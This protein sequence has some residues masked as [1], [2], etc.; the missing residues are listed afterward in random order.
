MFKRMKRIFGKRNN[1]GF[2][3]VEVIISCALLGILIAG[4]F[5]FVAPVM[6]SISIKEDNGRAL[7]LSEAIQTYINRSL[8]NSIY[9]LVIENAHIDDMVVGGNVPS[10]ASVVEMLATMNNPDYK[11]VYD[12]KCIGIRSMYDEKMQEYKYMLT[13]EFFVAGTASLDPTATQMVFEDCFYE[14][15][16]PKLTFK[17]LTTEVETGTDESGGPTLV[18]QEVPVIKTTADVYLDP[19]LTEL[20]F[21]QVG[22]INFGNIKS[23]FYNVSGSYKVYPYYTVRTPDEAKTAFPGENGLH[24]ATFIYY[25]TRKPKTAAPAAP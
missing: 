2:T 1:G 5:G 16:F 4:V 10:H 18:E 19:D 15:L 14:G 23:P 17:T 8:K 11:D 7:M 9:V 6:A 3:L 13:N 22:Y 20:S 24:P 25:I 21:E 12:L